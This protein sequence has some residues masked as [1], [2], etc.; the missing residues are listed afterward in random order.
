MS[1]S[2]K[3]SSSPPAT[4]LVNLFH[5][6]T[7]N[8]T[9]SN[10]L[11]DKLSFLKFFKNYLLSKLG[12]SVIRKIPKTLKIKTRDNFIQKENFYSI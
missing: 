10:S 5:Q 7:K 1:P 8:K 11:N 6:I 4:P 12:I 3:V 9:F 2:I